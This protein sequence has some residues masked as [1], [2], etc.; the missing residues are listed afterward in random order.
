MTETVCP[1]LLGVNRFFGIVLRET[2]LQV[3]GGTHVDL[4]WMA[5]AAEHV[6]VEH[7]ARLRLPLPRGGDRQPLQVFRQRTD[8]E[9]GLDYFSTKY[10]SSQYGRFISADPDSASGL[11]YLDDPQS[12]NSLS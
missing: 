11:V 12:F 8:T 7:F 6:D 5:R 10:N 1:S 4:C 9:S 3:T 2:P